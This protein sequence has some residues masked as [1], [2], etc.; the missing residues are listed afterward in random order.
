[1]IRGGGHL[2]KRNQG[3]FIL[4]DTFPKKICPC[5]LLEKKKFRKNIHPCGLQGRL[6][7]VLRNIQ[8]VT[9]DG[10]KVKLVEKTNVTILF[11]K[12]YYSRFYLKRKSTNYIEK[13]I[14]SALTCRAY[15]LKLHFKKSLLSPL[16][17]KI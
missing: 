10:L 7:K 15:F 13:I 2:D 8:S 14:Q 17:F 12:K 6:K 4:F 11:K 1:M 16:T 3:V 9:K 5:I